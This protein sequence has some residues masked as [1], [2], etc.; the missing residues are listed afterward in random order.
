MLTKKKAARGIHD[1]FLSRIVPK[2]DKNGEICRNKEGE[3]L[4]EEKPCTV[5]G[6]VR[7]LGLSR[8]EELEEIRDPKIRVLIDR[9]LLK[10]EE[11]AEEKLFQKDLFQGTKLFLATNFPRWQ[12]AAEQAPEET[13]DRGVF[14]IWGN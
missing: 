10:I 11:S 13:D 3:I 9:A 12:N 8:R 1:Y 7:A 5:S 4:T 6:L 14:A 2:L